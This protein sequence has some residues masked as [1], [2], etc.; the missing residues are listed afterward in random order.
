MRYA[1]LVAG[2]QDQTNG[3]VKERVDTRKQDPTLYKVVLLND[4]YS[5]MDF[6]IHILETVFQKSPAEAYRI[7]MQVHVEGRGIAGI[8]P[9]EIAETKVDTLTTMARESGYPLRA[10]IEPE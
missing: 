8:Y 6:V 5:T 3:A 9:H 7:T 10:T 4:D 2:Q 1:R